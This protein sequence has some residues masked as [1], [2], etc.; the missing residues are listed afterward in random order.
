MSTIPAEDYTRQRIH[1][2]QNTVDMQQQLQER[3]ASR[4][5]AKMGYGLCGMEPGCLIELNM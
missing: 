4:E 1:G 5:A 3:V 2:Q